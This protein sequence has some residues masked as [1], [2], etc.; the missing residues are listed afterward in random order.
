MKRS[1]HLGCSRGVSLALGLATAL[2]ANLAVAHPYATTLTNNAGT[3]SFRLNEAADTVEILWNNGA[4]KTNLGGLSKGLTITNV[5]ATSPFEVK[6]TKAG[7]G[8]PTRISDDANV[9]NQFEYPRG[10]FVN[11]RPASPY[12]GRIYVA[13]G[14]TTATGSGRSM[15]DGIYILNSDH[16][17]AL[18]QGNAALAGGLDFT[19]GGTSSP[20]HLTVGEDDDNLYIC[21]WSDATGNLYR[22][23]PSVSAASGQLVFP[24]CVG[25]AAVPLDPADNH[26]SVHG[27]AV[28]GS[29]AAGNL[30]VWQVDEDM[31]AAPSAGVNSMWRYDI[32]AGPLPY[33]QQPVWV[34]DSPAMAVAN[35]ADMARATNGY[36]YQLH[37]RSAG[38]Q[39]CLQ[40]VDPSGIVLWKSRDASVDPTNGWPHDIMSNSVSVAVSRDM[41]YLAALRTSG[42]VVVVPM[43]DGVPDLANRVEIAN[44]G[45][46]VSRQVAFDAANNVLVVDNISETLRVYSL[47]RTTTAITKSN[48]AGNGGEG[49]DFSM[50]S[51]AVTVSI[52]SDLAEV[53]EAAGTA[54]LTVTRAN[55]DSI[56]QPLTV[57]FVTSGTAVRGADYVLKT[58][59]VAFTQNAFVIPAGSAT[60]AVTLQAVD[61]SVAELTETAT[62]TIAG[63]TT[64]STGNPAAASVNILD[65]EPATADIVQVSGYDSMYERITT[66]YAR[67]RIVRR[68]DLN[69][70]QFTVNLA[71][72]GTATAGSDYTSVPTVTVDSTVVNQDFDINP[73]DD[74]L[75]EGPETITVSVAA[76]SGYTVGT[77]SPSAS[78]TIRDD[79]VATETVLYSENFNTDTSA[80]WNQLFGSYNG[81][82][83]YRCF[84]GY[85]YASGAYIPAI[86][87]APHSGGDTHGLYL[88][89][90]KDDA[91]DYG[92][93]G[94]NVYPKGKSFSGDYAVRFDM[95]LMVGDA[96]STTEYALMGICHSGTKTNWFRNSTTPAAGIPGGSFDGLFFGVE[97]DAAALG[98]YAIYSSP[99]TAGNNPTALTP[100]VSA[101]TM[102]G[103]F[104]VPPYDYDGAPGVIET[105]TTQPWSDVEISKVGSVVTL[106]INNTEIMRY[107]NST[108]YTVGNIMLGY[109]DAYDSIMT[110]HSGVVY[111]NLRVVSL[112]QPKVVTTGIQKVGSNIEIAFTYTSDDP[113]ASFGVKSSATAQGTYTTDATATITR[114]SAGVYKAVI[115]QS[116][117]MRFYRVMHN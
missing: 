20:W 24:K 42:I 33:S 97:A 7:T 9:F 81:A 73:I 91:S 45:Q 66:D 38:A 74:S 29:L 98:D 109:T 112:V 22:T 27:A 99:T 57:N 51:P 103:T 64:Y 37:Y 116:G 85:D 86:P 62:I 48:P 102:T 75:L 35:N 50:S 114:Q 93:A 34:A 84:F 54:A 63:T 77:N 4:S 104:K 47:G 23:D 111:D 65:N 96:A 18:G 69:A 26:G 14:R 53:G 87:A 1:T 72:S 79:E 67:L 12:F 30:T 16:T 70:G 94:V 92:A 15:G 46:A 8:T 41:K 32:G 61:D 5:G 6:V 40:V 107:T 101:S 82:T 28:S 11:R 52:V 31:D 115:P 2:A 13:N 25:T 21:D 17:D 3:V 108:T 19:T 58:N 89:V 100:G 55:Y 49:G 83:D 76:G 10:V 59:G 90:N 95:Y 39:N 113:A 88:T 78:V 44:G 36:L 106:K 43:M 110:G 80:Q 117:P 56:A 68:G 71:Y 105:S 60:L